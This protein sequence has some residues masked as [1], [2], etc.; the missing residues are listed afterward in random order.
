MLN[1]SK[2]N[3]SN[4]CFSLLLA[5]LFFLDLCIAQEKIITLNFTKN[6]S[7]ANYWWLEKNNFGRDISKFAF[8]G[9]FELEKSRTKYIISIFS[10]SKNNNIENIYLNES[11]IKHNFSNNTFIRLGRYYR[12]FSSYLNDDLS[13]GSML[14]S[15]NAQAMPK[16]GLV[17][18][19]KIKKNK[20]IIFDFGISH[21]IFNKNDIYKDSPFLH[22]K[23][24]YINIRKNNYKI[25][26]G[27]VHE[28]IWGGYIESDH[29][30]SGK[31]PNSFSDFL[32]ILIAED[33]P[34]DVPHANALGNHLGIWDFSIEKKNNDKI[35][36][37]YYQHL[38]EDTSGLRFANKTDGLWG[39]ELTEYL[40][41]TTVLLEYLNTSNQFIDFP[42][43]SEQYYNHFLYRP[44]WSYKNHTLGNPFIDHLNAIDTA[45]LHLGIK[46]TFSNN[47]NYTI[48]LSRRTNI[49]DKI[50]YKLALSKIINDKNQI[51][52]FMVNNDSANGFGISISKNL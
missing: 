12:D 10:K 49:S 20:N 40:F 28:A 41:N 44:G 51:D 3:N 25:A 14:I 48:K 50:K 29:K 35:L 34:E 33:G 23:F 36:K 19:K 26:I 1:L 37:L 11:F 47:Y 24:L 4:S 27:F 16:V 13:S 46:G 30:F 21:G 42:Y 32:K 5:I 22:E 15:N 6:P 43:V 2:K 31:Q 17:T 39:I 18:S 38:F 52:I 7:N 45:V 9:N 8:Q